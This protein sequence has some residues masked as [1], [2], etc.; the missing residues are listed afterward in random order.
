MQKTQ[1]PAVLDLRMRCL[2]GQ[3]RAVDRL[4]TEL[5]DTRRA[6]QAVSAAQS[7]RG[8]G[9][10]Q[11]GPHLA[12]WRPQDA[13]REAAAVALRTQLDALRALH[14]TGQYLQV[15]ERAEPLDHAV[16]AA[17]D[18][19][20]LS[21]LEWLW[22]DALVASSSRA[23]AV[24]V[25]Q[26]A[27][28]AAERTGDERLGALVHLSTHQVT[29]EP[30][31]SE[32]LQHAEAL[33]ARMGG[34]ARL[35]LKIRVA[36]GHGLISTDPERAAKSLEDAVAFGRRTLPADDLQ[37][38]TAISALGT[39]LLHADH[40]A[41]A[42][43]HLE[44]ALERTERLLGPRHPAMLSAIAPLSTVLL[45]LGRNEEGLA[46]ARRA[47]AIA[48]ATAQ[49]GNFRSSYVLT[50]LGT[51]LMA[52]GRFAEARTELERVVALDQS[53][54][55]S[56]AK[57]AWLNIAEALRAE[58]RPHEALAAYRRAEDIALQAGGR[59]RYLVGILSGTAEALLD[60][61]RP[62]E[63][64]AQARRAVAVCSVAACGP[65]RAVA[66]TSLG[67]AQLQTGAVALARRT[68]DEAVR[69]LTDEGAQPPDLACARFA[70][71]RVMAKQG[72]RAQARALAEAAAPVL[73]RHLDYA[74]VSQQLAAFLQTL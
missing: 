11:D 48:E 65:L 52:N 6:E 40:P 58:G 21:E 46:L 73:A 43:P 72:E 19:Y 49:P 37:L 42:V 26:R 45:E 60:L 36:R 9:A 18:D 25:L 39:A 5:D 35:E 74:R 20:L 50:A 68:L 55:H 3:L 16:Q 27:L 54:G 59:D 23:E 22:G 14:A 57:A 24:P 41:Q 8:W 28:L 7:L 13:E 33:V 29:S 61:S 31:A 66:L 12:R 10:C 44:E 4:M 70:L 15:R 64:L 30:L 63:A 69:Q 1:S 2:E 53:P 34:D 47:V 67:N 71:A 17:R 62:A 51:A 38:I 32:H 56:A